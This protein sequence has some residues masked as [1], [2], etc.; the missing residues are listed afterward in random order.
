MMRNIDNIFDGFRLIGLSTDMLKNSI[1]SFTIFACVIGTSAQSQVNLTAETTTPGGATYL[2][3]AHL[4]EIAGTRGIANIQLTDG[5]TLTNSIQNVAEG[6]TDIATSPYVLPFLMSRGLGP[7]GSLG[8]ERGA[9]LAENLRVINPFTLGIYFLTAYDSKNLGGW[10]DLKD[11]KIYNGPPRGGALSNARSIIKI[12]SRLKEGEDYEGIQVNWGQATKLV[13]S[14]EPDA[15]VIPLVF[16]GSN[17][18]TMVAAGAITS[19]S[20][21]KAA[22]EGEAMQKYMATPGSTPFI[23]PMADLK[24]IMGPDWRFI[25]EDDM[26]RGVAMIGGSV[27]HKNMDDALVYSLVSAYVATLQQLIAKAPY[28]DT[29][30]FDVPMQGMCGANPVK[31]HPAAARAWREAGFDLDDCAVADD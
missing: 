29:V 26:F 25:S 21:P 3:P 30:N 13:V 7:Y 8:V 2:S 4:A 12:V 10:N 19:W 20:I 11:R 1:I 28:G 22:H 5:Q 9:E 24:G 18:S 14:R 17:L 27:V 23:M 31:Y 15:I 16:R 6:K